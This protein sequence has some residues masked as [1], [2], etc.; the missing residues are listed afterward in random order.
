MTY[1]L[2]NYTFNQC[3]VGNTRFEN[4]HEHAWYQLWLHP[5]PSL[6]CPLQALFFTIFDISF[7]YKPQNKK[8]LGSEKARIKCNPEVL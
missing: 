4:S 7:G 2:I 8:V 5:N 3:L 6:I 1:T